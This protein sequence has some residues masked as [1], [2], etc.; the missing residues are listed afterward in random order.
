MI[1][2]TFKILNYINITSTFQEL[3]YD[4]SIFKILNR[5]ISV[6][7]NVRIWFWILCAIY[8]PILWLLFKFICELMYGN[9]NAALLCVQ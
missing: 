3:Y 5:I 8:P 2:H 6:F 1:T 9:A 7:N 4:T